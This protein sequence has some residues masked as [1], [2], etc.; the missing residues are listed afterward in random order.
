MCMFSW[1][2]FPDKMSLAGKLALVTG[3]GSGIGRS[4]CQVDSHVVRR[5]LR[6]AAKSRQQ[7]K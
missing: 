2:F 4:I 1:V 3:G 5:N 7:A 6:V